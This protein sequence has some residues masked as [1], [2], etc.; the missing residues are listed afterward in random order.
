M[1]LT[2]PNFN[3][4]TTTV[5][6]ITDP[7]LVVNKNS[8][9]ANVDIGFV[10]NRDGGSTSNVALIWDETNDQFVLGLTSNSGATNSNVVVSSYANVT[11][12]NLTVSG[13]TGN[14]IPSAN[15]TYSLGDETH[16][17]KSLYVSGS[18]IYIGGTPLTVSGGTLLVDGQEVQGGGSGN[19]T[20]SNSTPGSANYGDLWYDTD[21]DV[22]FQYINDGSSNVWVDISTEAI[23]SESSFGTAN[24]N[25]LLASW[26]SNTLSTTGNIS[27]GNITTSGSFIGDGSQLTGLPAGYTDSDVKTLLGADGTVTSGYVLS[28][29]SGSD[30]FSWV[31]SAGY[32]DSDVDAHLSGGTGVTYSS[33]TISIGQAVGTGNSPTFNR[34]YCSQVVASGRVA[35]SEVSGHGISGTTSLSIRGGVS[36]DGVKLQF[37][38]SDWTD[39]LS[40]RQ[41]TLDILASYPFTAT[42]NISAGG[43]LTDNYYYANGTP[44]VGGGGGGAS[45]LNDL[46]DVTISSPSNG[47]VLKYNGS[48]WVNGTDATGEGGGG[49]TSG[50]ETQFLLMG[51]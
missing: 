1:A 26:G 38:D 19:F 6:S 29:D 22:L 25:T 28:Y 15:V 4:I 10:F 36:S 31:D 23:V 32:T 13:I 7:L 18:T 8:T 44:F 50:F 45:T 21:T 30:S 35:A 41:G 46:S 24:V 17:W 33:G 27:A 40:I 20:T 9:A 5:T 11:A 2:R 48:A 3:N 34:V 14:L 43:V 47:Q 51:A 39:A 12:G 16:W 42:G 37:F 49:A